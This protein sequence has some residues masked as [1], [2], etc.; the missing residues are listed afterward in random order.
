MLPAPEPV[1]YQNSLPEGQRLHNPFVAIAD[2]VHGVAP[3]LMRRFMRQHQAAQQ[4][5]QVGIANA[6]SAA[7][8]GREKCGAGKIDQAG[9]P[10]VFKHVLYVIKENRTYDQVFGD[11]AAGEGDPQLCIFGEHVTPNHHKLAG[12][13]LL[14]DNF[15]CSGALSADGHQWTDEACVTDYIEKSFGGFQRSY[16]YDGNDAMAYARS[17]FLWDNALARGR[18]LRVYGEFVKGTV[19]WHRGRVGAGRR[20]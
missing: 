3:P 17:G 2:P 15:Y 6:D 20:P 4:K 11:V 18:T 9:E 8:V 12:E 16:P 7:L 10:S 1:G 5:L 19:R 13:F 14:L